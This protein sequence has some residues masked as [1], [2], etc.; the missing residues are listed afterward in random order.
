MIHGRTILLN[1]KDIRTYSPQDVLRKLVLSCRSH[2]YLQG[3]SEKISCT[4]MPC[5]INLVMNIFKGIGGC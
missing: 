2:F 3:Q 4:A 1:G 5:I